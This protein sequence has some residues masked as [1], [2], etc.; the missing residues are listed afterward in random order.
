M[1]EVYRGSEQVTWPFYLQ[2][3]YHVTHQLPR[4]IISHVPVIDHVTIQSAL[5]TSPLAASHINVKCA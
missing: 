3:F 4:V 2:W 5:V 1:G